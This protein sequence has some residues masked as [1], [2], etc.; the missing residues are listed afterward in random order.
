MTK[1]QIEYWKLRETAKHNELSRKES[2]RSNREK[3][4][5]QEQGNRYSFTI[6]QGN[7]AETQRANREKELETNRS[8]VENEAIKR[9]ANEV[10]SRNV[11]VNRMNALTNAR[12]ADSNAYNATT[13]AMNAQTNL[14]ALQEDERAN[15]R[16]EY[17]QFAE[18]E[19][20]KKSHRASETQ[21]N[22]DNA[23]T[24]S[25]QS[26]RLGETKRHDLV[27][28]AET[29]RKNLIDQKTRLAELQQKINNDQF[30]TMTNLIG[31]MKPN[32]GLRLGGQY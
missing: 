5:I 30:T 10:S 3:E 28:E 25:D 29:A 11:D 31:N 20:T 32:I 8:N 1:N 24:A 26:N 17:Q 7:L 22:L 2:E 27:T 23:L 19:E 14:R 12:N 6:G 15:R 21:K 4:R 16:R 9:F 13:N 18:L